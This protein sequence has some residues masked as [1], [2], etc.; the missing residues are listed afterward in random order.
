MP[1][2][3]FSFFYFY[4]NSSMSIAIEGLTVSGKSG[5]V[6]PTACLADKSEL[7]HAQLPSLEATTV[8]ATKLRRIH[9]PLV[10]LDPPALPILVL[11]AQLTPV[12]LALLDLPAQL[13]HQILQA[14]LTL[15]THLNLLVLLVLSALQTLVVAV[16]PQCRASEP[17]SLLINQ[18]AR[19]PPT[20]VDLVFEYFLALHDLTQETPVVLTSLTMSSLSSTNP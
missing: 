17:Q 3:T 7:E 4:L 1:R 19:M 8:L 18:L 11:S 14:L 6:G 13:A 10:L 12:T 9:A 5:L 15:R 20:K 16:H 2:Y